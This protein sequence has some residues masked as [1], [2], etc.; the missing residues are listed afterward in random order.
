MLRP[1]PTAT[2]IHLFVGWAVI[3]WAQLEWCGPI[4][5]HMK[6]DI[7]VVGAS[8]GGVEALRSLA[9]GIPAD[10]DGTIL[11]VLHVPASGTSVLPAI[12]T[13]AGAL[14]ARHAV[15]DDVLHPGEIVIAPPDHHLVAT[16]TGLTIVRGPRENGHRPAVDVLF[17]SAARTWGSR[18]VA[19]VLSGVLDD[20]TAGCRSVQA[21]GGILI[22]Q[23]PADAL[24]PEMPMNVVKHALV[25]HVVAARDMGSLLAT[26]SREELPEPD[27]SRANGL[28]VA[29]TDIAVMEGRAMNAHE[30][31]GVP[32]GYG[33]PDCNGSLFEIQDGDQVRYRCRV[34]HGW[35]SQGLLAQQSLALDSAL[36][37]ALRSLE[38][39][40]ALLAQLGDQADGRGSALTAQRYHDQSGDTTE[41]ANLVR[42][43]LEK[44]PDMTPPEAL[45]E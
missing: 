35:T 5:E 25:D 4:G 6:R 33:C 24:Y 13:R 23:D 44:V 31:P 21:R 12:L 37:M 7:V 42:Q 32:A 39:K 41:A 30:R 14:P 34:G 18:V 8:A 29:E 9:A 26:I 2:A 17:R 22:T 15:V 20:G 38:E 16:D 36:W 11:I 1:N 43:L 28:L 3:R 10:F 27:G 45:H 40:A 19:V